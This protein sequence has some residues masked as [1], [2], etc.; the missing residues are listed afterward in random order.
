MTTRTTRNKIRFQGKS[1]LEDLRRAQEHLT[2]LAAL[3]D[4]NS[5][6]INDNLPV[7][8]L[9]IESVRVALSSFY[10]GL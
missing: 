5:P 3:A 8:M 1:A 4:D 9:S 10:E 6:Y 2:G 7:I